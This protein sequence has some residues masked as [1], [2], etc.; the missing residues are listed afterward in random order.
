MF[1]RRISLLIYFFPAQGF[2]EISYFDLIHISA[3]LVYGSII[4]RL[5]PRQQDTRRAMSAWDTV[6]H[7]RKVKYPGAVYAPG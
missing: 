6:C 7:L 2:N 1:S 4:A 3:S 5:S